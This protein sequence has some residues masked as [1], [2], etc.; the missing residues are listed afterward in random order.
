MIH[1][2][3]TGGRALACRIGDLGSNPGPSKN[4]FLKVNK[5][6][7]TYGQSDNNIL[8][9]AEIVIKQEEEDFLP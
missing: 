2:G 5:T 3:G 8:I 6:E 4:F 7:P 9:D 1:S